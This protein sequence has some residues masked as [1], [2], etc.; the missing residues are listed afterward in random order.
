MKTKTKVLWGVPSFLVGIGVFAILFFAYEIIP[1]FISV[2][3][4][5]IFGAV[6]LVSSTVVLVLIPTSDD[7]RAKASKQIRKTVTG[8]KRVSQYEYKKEPNYKLGLVKA[9]LAFIFFLFMFV[10]ISF[11]M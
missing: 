10:L 3:Y 2:N 9:G 4:L 6:F 7:Q 11:S 8:K 5:M 1:D